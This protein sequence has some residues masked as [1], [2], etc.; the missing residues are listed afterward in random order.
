MNVGG[1]AAEPVGQIIWGERRARIGE[2]GQKIFQVS[3]SRFHAEIG[4]HQTEMVIRVASVSRD[5]AV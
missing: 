1:S 5:V 4:V 2:D 3:V